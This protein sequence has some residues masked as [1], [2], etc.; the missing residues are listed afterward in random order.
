MRLARARATAIRSRPR[1]LAGDVAV[2]SA[3]A[4]RL[5]LSDHNSA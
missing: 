5:E 4:A 2:L 3:S 1:P